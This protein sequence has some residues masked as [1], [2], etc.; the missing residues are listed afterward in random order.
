MTAYSLVDNKSTQ[1]ANIIVQN[2]R[3]EVQIYPFS[4][5]ASPQ[6]DLIKRFELHDVD[7]VC[8][9]WVVVPRNEEGSGQKKRNNKDNQHQASDF[10]SLLAVALSLGVIK[11]FSAFSDD[12]VQNITQV[13]PVKQ[14]SQS[15]AG[16][17]WGITRDGRIVHINIRKPSQSKYLHTRDQAFEQV[18]GLD[19][20]DKTAPLVGSFEEKAFII[21]TTKERDNVVASSTLSVK[22]RSPVTHIAHI[23]DY[24]Y[25]TYEDLNTVYMR[26]KK[27]F[28]KIAGEIEIQGST[29]F[30]LIPIYKNYL[31]VITDKGIEVYA[32]G[33]F[34]CLISS[35]VRLENMFL[36]RLN[37][38]LVWYDR[39]QPKFVKIDGPE[40]NRP[41]EI[42]AD[43][44][45][46]KTIKAHG[47]ESHLPE[48]Q[49][50]PVVN[51]EPSRL[52]QKL[53]DLLLSSNTVKHY[54]KGVTELCVANDDED[55][56][57]ETV[58]LL[59]QS[60]LRNI[61]V[62]RL[63]IC[64]STRVAKEPH[65]K[66]SLAVWL[67]WILLT[68]GGLILR[69]RDLT[70]HLTSLESGLEE[71]V[72]ILLRLLALR[73]R[74]QMLRSQAEFRNRISRQGQEEEVE[75][76]SNEESG[77]EDFTYD[78]YDDAEKDATVNGEESIIFANGEN[79]DFDS[80]ADEDISEAEGSDDD[81]E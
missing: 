34:V 60:D 45:G 44:K 65:K 53:K 24:V 18:L 50:D 55:N 36:V 61:L 74:M 77:D 47:Q 22:S 39:N 59:S 31:A 13:L 40:L 1:L 66:T 46:N 78:G 26:T 10:H 75:E 6:N 81:D 51:Q 48:E 73:G 52:L 70:K 35:D 80:I 79:D 58:R 38:V 7:I 19:T 30:K 5:K 57:K 32:D 21:S 27:E 69:N 49:Y 4:K 67:R 25:T 20:N 72:S 2:G 54:R 43:N 41:V 64:V 15:R 62:E 11:L 16:W 71:G 23:G 12:A 33:S 63:F 42:I 9:T 8:A 68:H 56:I 28:K 3:S 29:I 14:L 17:C 76:D 37:Y